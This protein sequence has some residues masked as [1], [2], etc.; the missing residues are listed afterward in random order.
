MTSCLNP[1]ADVIENCLFFVQYWTKAGNN[2]FKFCVDEN[3]YRLSQSS[4][5]A[6]DS[7]TPLIKIVR[8]T[9]IRRPIQRIDCIAIRKICPAYIVAFVLIVFASTTKQTRKR[10]KVLAA[11]TVEL[12]GKKF[13]K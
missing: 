13:Y 6:N 5:D 1:P 10:S 2:Y 7:L 11:Y 8:V 9:E 12:T 3:R 4:A